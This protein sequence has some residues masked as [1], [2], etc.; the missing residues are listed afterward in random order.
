M[1]IKSFGHC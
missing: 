1:V